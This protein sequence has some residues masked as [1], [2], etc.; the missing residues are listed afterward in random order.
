MGDVDRAGGLPTFERRFRGIDAT[1]ND[2]LGVVKARRSGSQSFRASKGKTREDAM[3]LRVLMSRV[4][5]ARAEG[6]PRSRA[7]GMMKEG[8]VYDMGGLTTV[9]RRGFCD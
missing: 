7:R 1:G 2:R 8:D 5:R 4:A 9:C 3:V 6:K